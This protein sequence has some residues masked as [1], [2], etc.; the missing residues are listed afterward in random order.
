MGVDR[1]RGER[2]GLA[3]CS[4]YLLVAH[5]LLAAIAAAGGGEELDYVGAAFY[6]ALRTLV[7]NFA[8]SARAF[9][10]GWSEVRMRGPGD[11]GLR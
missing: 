1:E 4:F 9:V 8:G 5:G 2:G 11:S 7:A 3:A 6:Q 10:E